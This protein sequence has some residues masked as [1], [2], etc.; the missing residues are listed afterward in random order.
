MNDVPNISTNASN[1]GMAHQQPQARDQLGGLPEGLDE[2]YRVRGRRAAV[3]S[4]SEPDDARVGMRSS[5]AEWMRREVNL[6]S[7]AAERFQAC[8]KSR[9]VAGDLD[10][11]DQHAFLPRSRRSQETP[12][13]RANLTIGSWTID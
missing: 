3:D 6:H 13:V 2:Q 11:A 10:E 4:L 5:V 8:A 1:L 9:P 12:R 7:C